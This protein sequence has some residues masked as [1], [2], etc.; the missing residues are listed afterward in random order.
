VAPRNIDLGVTWPQAI[1]AG[2]QA[3]THVAV[4]VVAIR[5]RRS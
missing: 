1:E 2:L 3:C 5:R 4:T